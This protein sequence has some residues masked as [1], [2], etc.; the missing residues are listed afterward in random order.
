MEQTKK[1]SNNSQTQ[2]KPLQQTNT[3]PFP[4][5]RD[6]SSIPDPN[7]DTHWEKLGDQLW[8]SNEQSK[9]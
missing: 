3:Q 9:K 7:S 8:N 5:Y 1:N 4:K 6:P 2:Q